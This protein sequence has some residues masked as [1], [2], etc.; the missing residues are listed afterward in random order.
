MKRKDSEGCWVGG[1]FYKSVDAQRIVASVNALAGITDPE[2]WV[3]AA[4]ELIAYSGTR[5][6]DTSDRLLAHIR[7]AET[8]KEPE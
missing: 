8:G 3:K 2:A 4:R 7:A 6:G 5:A 1:R